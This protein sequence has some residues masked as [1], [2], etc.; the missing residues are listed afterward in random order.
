MGFGLLQNP[1]QA[2]TG[3]QPHPAALAVRLQHIADFGCNILQ[4]IAGIVGH[5]ALYI[6]QLQSI[7]AMQPGLRDAER[8]QYIIVLAGTSYK[9]AQPLCK[10]SCEALL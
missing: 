6:K 7:H 10:L 4:R 5:L 3:V 2:I 9:G 8:Q 1:L